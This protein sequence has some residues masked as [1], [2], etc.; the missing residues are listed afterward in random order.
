LHCRSKVLCAASSNRAGAELFPRASNADCGSDSS[1]AD[2]LR[3][4][5]PFFFNALT[6]GQ[7]GNRSG[8]LP[9]WS[10]NCAG[11]FMSLRHKAK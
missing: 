10:R 8:R 7:A 6:A 4:T 1:Y 9:P 2:K 3:L 5:A 11:K